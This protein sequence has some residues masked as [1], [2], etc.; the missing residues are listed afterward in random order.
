MLFRHTDTH[1]VIREIR[2]L[3]Y[4]KCANKTYTYTRAYTCNGGYIQ[5]VLLCDLS[6]RA[7]GKNSFL[8]TSK[9]HEYLL[10]M[11]ETSHSAGFGDEA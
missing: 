9:C 4:D 7:S 1:L 3:L 11:T 5:G 2:V 8:A 6:E 10:R